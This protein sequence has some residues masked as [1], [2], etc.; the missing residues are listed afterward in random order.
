MPMYEYRCADCGSEFEQL[1]S[2]NTPAEDVDCPNCGAYEASRTL[3]I[4]AVGSGIAAPMGEAC[5]APVA[6]PPTSTCGHGMCGLHDS[7]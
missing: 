1:V 4:F 5:E 7:A 3:S 2:F 6:A